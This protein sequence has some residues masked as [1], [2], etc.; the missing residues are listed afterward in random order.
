LPDEPVILDSQGPV[1]EV[2]EV[3]PKRDPERDR[4]IAWTAAQVGVVQ[5]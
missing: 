4:Q 3:L 2:A 1:D 5:G